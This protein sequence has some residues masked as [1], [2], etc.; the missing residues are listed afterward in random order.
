MAK[1]V[2]GLGD[3]PRLPRRHSRRPQGTD[4]KLIVS[5]SIPKT[6]GVAMRKIALETGRSASEL[7]A[8]AV[9]YWLDEALPGWDAE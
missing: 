6:I 7:Y 5:I 9:Q 2:V 1:T 8:D 3:L 4:K